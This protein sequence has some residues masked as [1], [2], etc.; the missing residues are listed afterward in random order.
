MKGEAKI[1]LACYSAFGDRGAPKRQAQAA[2]TELEDVWR[3]VAVS[4]EGKGAVC[5]AVILGHEFPTS[6]LL[7]SP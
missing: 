6:V 2:K 3:E 1:N 7:W 5:H 4:A